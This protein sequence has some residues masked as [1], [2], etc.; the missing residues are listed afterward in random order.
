[1]KLATVGYWRVST[2]RQGREGVSLENQAGAGA[3]WCESHGGELVATFVED[4]SAW[5]KRGAKR[6]ALAAA[7]AFIR[8]QGG[9]VRFFLVYDLSRFAR[10]MR[11]QIRLTDEL[12]ALG[13]ELQTCTLDLRDD[14]HGRAVA[15]YLGVTNQLQSD[16]ASEKIS[17][18]MLD[19]VRRGRS[20]HLAPIGYRNGRDS[21]G[22]KVIEPDPERAPLVRRAFELAAS[23]VG[24]EA[25]AAELERLGARGRRGGRLRAQE[26]RA[27]LGR[28]IYCGVVE[29]RK[30]GVEAPGEHEA[31]VDRELWERAQPGRR[32]V[33]LTPGV[34]ALSSPALP[35]QRVHPD[36]PLRGFVRCGAC[37]RPLTAA[38]SRGRHGGRFGYYHCW[39]AGCRAERV[40]SVR[41]E[42]A[43]EARLG[44]VALSPVQVAGVEAVLAGLWRQRRA[45]EEARRA[46]AE[47]ERAELR[48]RRDRLVEA[49]VFQQ[50]IDRETYDRQLERIDRALAESYFE[51][52]AGGAPP[53]DLGAL[54]VAARPL[55]SAPSELWRRGDVETKRRLQALVYPA[56]A[57]LAGGELRTPETACIF[58][59]FRLAQVARGEVV[60][61]SRATS[62]PGG[63][64]VE[65]AEWIQ[66]AAEVVRLAA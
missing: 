8:S 21:A 58:N 66:R 40:R 3:R 24:P 45:D 53:A 20:P 42:A 44:A 55:L 57:L 37:G 5:T 62:N 6:P 54:L 65:L 18:T 33:N 15:G 12:R 19:V 11:D 29:S 56:G 32:K 16:L 7:L 49:F 46:A 13:V 14:A 28:R 34:K 25:I 38:H 48:R 50:S 43:F 59:A 41:L 1:M 47:R 9:R 35:H 64:V 39:A 60:E 61:Q 2:D 51:P 10:S 4:E 52:R 63:A 23:G 31:L 36:F 30:H 22:R 17:A 27:M 26:V